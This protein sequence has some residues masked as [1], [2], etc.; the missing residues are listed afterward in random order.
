MMTWLL[1]GVNDNTE[2]EIVHPVQF[3]TKLFTMQ[4]YRDFGFILHRV[5]RRGNY[6]PCVA[7]S[8]GGVFPVDQIKEM[9]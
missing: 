4:L 3:R 8:I 7:Y 9:W 1:W 6:L 2:L 5:H